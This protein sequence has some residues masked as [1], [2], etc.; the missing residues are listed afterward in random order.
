MYEYQEPIVAAG[1]GGFDNQNIRDDLKYLNLT[2]TEI[3]KV[4]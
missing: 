3:R 2:N 4:I 1:S